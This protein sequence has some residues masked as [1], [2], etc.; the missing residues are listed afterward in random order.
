M[1][2]LLSSKEWN[3]KDG[4]NG[5]WVIRQSGPAFNGDAATARAIRERI[6]V[7]RRGLCTVNLVDRRSAAT[8]P[9]S[10][11]AAADPGGGASFA[12]LPPGSADHSMSQMPQPPPPLSTH[13]QGEGVPQGKGGDRALFSALQQKE[14]EGQKKGLFAKIGNAWRGRRGGPPP[15]KASPAG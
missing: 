4:L 11:A 7:A 3:E 6:A 12:T 9:I 14:A 1:A 2:G 13:Q 5:G 8:G 10:A 15:P